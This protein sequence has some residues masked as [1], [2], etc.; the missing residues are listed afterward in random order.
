MA[1]KGQLLIISAA[2]LGI[3]TKIVRKR[4]AMERE[5]RKRFEDCCKAGV[6]KRI[7]RTRR[8][9]TKEKTVMKLNTAPV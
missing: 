8:L 6:L 3:M 7:T 4:S 1:P 9:V 2:A 5:A